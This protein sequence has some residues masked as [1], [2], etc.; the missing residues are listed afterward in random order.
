MSIT[1][2]RHGKLSAHCLEQATCFLLQDHIDHKCSTPQERK[3]FSKTDSTQ[4]C[5]SRN[6]QDWEG[7]SVSGSPTNV[8]IQQ[9]MKS[10]K[11]LWTT[12]TGTRDETE[13]ERTRTSRRMKQE[14]TQKQSKLFKV[15]AVHCTSHSW[16][17]YSNFTTPYL[18]NNTSCIPFQITD[19]KLNTFLT[20]E[21]IEFSWMTFTDFFYSANWDKI[22]KW[23]GY[24]G[25]L[26]TNAWSVVVIIDF[27]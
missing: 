11:T 25:Y 15:K 23:G 9:E 14:E 12:Q 20:R 21:T 1:G 16:T 4:Y 22:P 3:G 27:M 5:N 8:Q 18:V 2:W 13:S 26:A 6:T 17:L 7:S 19:Y 24:Q 10:L